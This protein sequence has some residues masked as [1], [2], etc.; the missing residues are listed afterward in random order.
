MAR[1]SVESLPLDFFYHPSLFL[2]PFSAPSSC[3]FFC[4][5]PPYSLLLIA[6][7]FLT[8]GLSAKSVFSPFAFP[9]LVMFVSLS[10]P[11]SSHFVLLATKVGRTISSRLSGGDRVPLGFPVF[12]HHFHF[13]P[14]LRF[15]NSKG[16]FFP[17]PFL[18]FFLPSHLLESPICIALTSFLTTQD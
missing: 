16:A 12:L 17:Q 6:I 5:P 4:F 13:L 14:C 3:F 15:R 2:I 10:A 1:R 7:L 18:F 11:F 9:S 8:P